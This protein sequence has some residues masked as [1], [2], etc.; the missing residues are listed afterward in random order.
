MVYVCRKCGR[1]FKSRRAYMFHI[2]IGVEGGYVK[3][4]K[5]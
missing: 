2:L 1:V 5:R 4:G 3:K